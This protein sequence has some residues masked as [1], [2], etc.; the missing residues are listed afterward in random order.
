MN[1]QQTIKKMY[2]ILLVFAHNMQIME[3]WVLDV[4]EKE[5]KKLIKTMK[6]TAKKLYKI[7]KVD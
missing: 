4:S 5:K 3:S 1:K 6:D 2:P 7:I